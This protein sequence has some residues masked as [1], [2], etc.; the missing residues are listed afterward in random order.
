MAVGS[1][2]CPTRVYFRIKM[3][4]RASRLERF[5]RMPREDL[6]FDYRMVRRMRA[7]PNPRNLG[8]PE[9]TS[10]AHTQTGADYSTLKG[11]KSRT[12][13]NVPPCIAAGD[14]RSPAGLRDQ[15]AL[16]NRWSG[17][18]RGS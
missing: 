15:N 9:T 4:R 6:K 3:V 16:I 14:H 7:V 2:A 18:D 1:S 8:H 5:S 17:G 10:F 11:F 12:K 13:R